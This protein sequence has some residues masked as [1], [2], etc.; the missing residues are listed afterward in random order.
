MQMQVLDKRNILGEEVVTY[1]DAENPL[2]LA[3]DIAIW[4]DERDGYTVS[5][6]VDE[7]E[8]L[9]HKFC[10]PGDTQEREHT[11]LTEEGLYEI[12]MQSRKPM[13]KEFKK[14]VKKLLKEIRLNKFNPYLNMSKELQAIFTLDEKQ[15]K[16]ENKV[17]EIENKMTLNY[18]LAENIRTNISSR[19]IEVLE[20][21][22]SEAYKKC[23]K[24][25]FT[26]MHREL[27]KYFKVNSYKN[28]SIK[29]YDEAIDYIRAWYP[30][31][32]LRLE[33]EM[34]NRQ[35]NFN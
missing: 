31:T 24:K 23:S 17:I 15:Q 35:V 7:D 20:G 33:I 12:L 21:K 26:S 13:A 2:F 30:E 9:I 16:L 11:L 1:G 29:K 5:R 10:V 18:E 28:L 4:I 8:K 6:K 3:R 27:K 34:V 25:V 19:A 14:R 22:Y 32:N